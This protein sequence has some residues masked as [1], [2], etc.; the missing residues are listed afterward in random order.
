VLEALLAPNR[1]DIAVKRHINAGWIQFSS[2]TPR[3]TANASEGVR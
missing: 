3:L 1:E 2:A